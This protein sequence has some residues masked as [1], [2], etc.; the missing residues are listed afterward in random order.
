M[1]LQMALVQIRIRTLK[2]RNDQM[3]T[4][5]VDVKILVLTCITNP[6]YIMVFLQSLSTL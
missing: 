4:I 6:S 3:M 5:M 2:H 1:T